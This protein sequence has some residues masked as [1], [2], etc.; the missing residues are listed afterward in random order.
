MCLAMGLQSAA[1]AHSEKVGPAIL[2]PEDLARSR[3]E[4]EQY[5]AK[6][7]AVEREESK[8]NVH[9]STETRQGSEKKPVP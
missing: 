3:V 4:M 8:R 7:E 1:E 5:Q 6:Q 2:N 9:F